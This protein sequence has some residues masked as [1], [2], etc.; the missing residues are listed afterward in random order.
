MKQLLLKIKRDWSILLL[1]ALVTGC[2]NSR[3][4]EQGADVL[5]QQDCG[6][7]YIPI[8]SVSSY[9]KN[10]LL[11]IE[12]LMVVEK[13]GETPIKWDSEA[14]WGEVAPFWFIDANL[15]YKLSRGG[16]KEKNHDELCNK[17]V[18]Y[19]HAIKKA[20]S[21]LK[22]TLIGYHNNFDDYY[23]YAG[24]SRPGVRSF[25]ASNSGGKKCGELVITRG[26]DYSKSYTY[27]SHQIPD[28]AVIVRW[29]PAR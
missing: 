5:S 24:P 15:A 7:R 8:S 4:Q 22:E 12:A 9:D 2:V 17:I 18:P 25:V 1:A 13:D 27:C 28:D 23:F 10:N 3:P 16:T 6:Y 20:S 19:E 14:D 29:F 21:E 11:G 26:K